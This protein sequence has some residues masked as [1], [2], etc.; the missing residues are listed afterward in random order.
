MHPDTMEFK[1]TM[2]LPTSIVAT[3]AL[4]PDQRRVPQLVSGW[5]YLFHVSHMVCILT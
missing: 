4:C 3:G 5:L 2:F 1:E